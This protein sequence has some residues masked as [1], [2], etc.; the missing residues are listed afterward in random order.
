MAKRTVFNDEEKDGSN[1][2]PAEY[3]FFENKKGILHW[4][5]MF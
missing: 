4:K 3:F 5:T 2:F 1:H